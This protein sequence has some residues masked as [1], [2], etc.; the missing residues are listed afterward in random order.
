MVS[1]STYVLSFPSL[2]ANRRK[3]LREVTTLSRLHHPN[4]VRYYQAWIERCHHQPGEDEEDV[5]HLD[6]DDDDEE[7]AAADEVGG[8]LDRGRSGHHHHNNNSAFDD[9]EDDA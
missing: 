3:L 8:R 9:D 7:A 5:L 4:I 1:T 6:D 2:L